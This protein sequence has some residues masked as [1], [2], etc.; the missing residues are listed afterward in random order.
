VQA[1]AVLAADKAAAD[2]AELDVNDTRSHALMLLQLLAT[3]LNATPS[4]V[5]PGLN[6]RPSGPSSTGLP[7]SQV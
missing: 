5:F 2:L 3:N 6:P 7:D 4:D 1:E